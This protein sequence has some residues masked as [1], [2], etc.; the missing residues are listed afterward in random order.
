MK[1]T[2]L[3]VL[4]E[5]AKETPDLSYMRGLLEGLVEDEVP[6]PVATS[7]ITPVS[8]AVMSPGGYPI[9]E[10]EVTLEQL[11]Q[12]EQKAREMLKNNPNIVNPIE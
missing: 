7:F 6:M 9:N 2:L 8:P 11:N 1:K 12:L 3:K 10:N 5:L 4:A